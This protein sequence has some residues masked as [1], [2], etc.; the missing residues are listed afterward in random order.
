MIDLKQASRDD[1][2][3]LVIAQHERITA[4]EAVVAEQRAV[5]ATLETSVA[6]LTQRVGELLAAAETG[7]DAAGRGRPPGMPGL[8]P[9]TS[10]E[11]PAKAPRKRREQ[12]FVRQRMA[13]TRPVIHALEACPQ[14]GMPL[15]GVGLAGELFERGEDTIS[16][17]RHLAAAIARLEV[18]E[19]GLAKEHLRRFADR[20]GT[21]QT[22]L[23]A[24]EERDLT[25]ILKALRPWDTRRA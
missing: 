1:L 16:V 6:Q 5:I 20:V 13:P 23:T 25:D 7:D 11:R 10:K 14:C 22:W 3:R 18:V 21:K 8:K 24:A 9:A 17:L 4:L 2:I 12:A 19:R 15:V